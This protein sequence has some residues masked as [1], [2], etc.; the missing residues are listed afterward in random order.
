MK[1]HVL[2]TLKKILTMYMNS[3]HKKVTLGC[4]LPND[5]PLQHIYSLAPHCT[6]NY[7]E[8]EH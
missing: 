3:M 1:C 6:L 4:R 2:D 7:H 8:V 5:A